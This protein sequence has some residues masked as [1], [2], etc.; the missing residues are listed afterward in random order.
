MEY[1]MSAQ[2]ASTILGKKKHSNP[3]KVLCD[4]V[5]ESFGLLYPCTKV[6]IV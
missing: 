5:N 3:Q 4:F 2:M 1:C 6:N